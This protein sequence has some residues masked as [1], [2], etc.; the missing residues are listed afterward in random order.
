MYP[1]RFNMK[2]PFKNDVPKAASNFNQFQRSKFIERVSVILARML[3]WQIGGCGIGFEPTTKVE[4]SEL[5]VF[6]K[7][8]IQYYSVC[9]RI[10]CQV[11]CWKMTEYGA[12]SK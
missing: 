2:Q 1:L 7:M 11:H 10:G 12:A 6:H 5:Y 4:D 8:N 3:S 9:C